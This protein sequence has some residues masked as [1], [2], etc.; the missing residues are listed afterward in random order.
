MAL[1]SLD[2]D[3][4]MT[5]SSSNNA[6]QLIN[7]RDRDKGYRI[8][9]KTTIRGRNSPLPNRNF[10]GHSSDSRSSGFLPIG[11][12]NWY[13]VTVSNI[14]ILYYYIITTVLYYYCIT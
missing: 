6:R 5:G 2:E 14:F 7:V 4:P 13:R 12:S 11:D 10:K 8:W 3:I 1:T 9:Q